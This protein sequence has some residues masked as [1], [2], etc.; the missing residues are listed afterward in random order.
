MKQKFFAKIAIALIIFS[1][2]IS[3]SLSFISSTFSTPH[4]YAGTTTVAPNTD[5]IN[6]QNQQTENTISAQSAECGSLDLFCALGKFFSYILLFVP[7]I[8]TTITGMLFDMSIWHSLQSSTYTKYDG[9]VGNEGV[10]VTGWKLVRDF[11][12][13]L[14]IFALFA[15]AFSLILNVNF[16]LEPKKTIA[17]VVVMAL[18]VNFSFFF[19]RAL[20]DVSNTLALSFYNNMTSAPEMSAA[21]SD[22]DTATKNA[23]GNPAGFY[24]NAGGIRSISAALIS[25]INPHNLVLLSTQSNSTKSWSLSTLVINIVTSFMVAVFNIFLIYIFLSVAILFVARTIGI[26]IAVILSPIAFVSRTIPKLENK[27]YIGF[28]DWLKQLVG[29]AFMGP[30]YL[31]FLYITIQFLNIGGTSAGDGQIFALSAQIFFKLL[32]VGF[33]MY[34]SKKI[35]KDMSGRIGEM[36]VNAVSSVATTGAMF[37]GAAAT[38]G[39][40]GMLQMG[41]RMATDSIK[42]GAINVGTRILGEE[43]VEEIRKRQGVLMNFANNPRAAINASRKIMATGSTG[44]PTTLGKI[45]DAF[46]YGGVSNRKF[47]LEQ[48]AKAADTAKKQKAAADAFKTRNIDKKI[49][50][51]KKDFDDGVKTKKEYEEKLKELVLEKRAVLDPTLSEKN[52]NVSANATLAAVTKERKD[53]SLDTKL[54]TTQSKI[55][56]LDTK[57]ATNTTALANAATKL[58]NAV[59]DRQLANKEVADKKSALASRTN[60]DQQLQAELVSVEK[61]LEGLPKTGF[62]VDR[63]KISALEQKRSDISTKRSLIAADIAKMSVELNNL[64]QQEKIALSVEDAAI[65][66]KDSLEAADIEFKRKKSEAENEKNV[67]EQEKIRLDN[68]VSDAEKNLQTSEINLINKKES[69]SLQNELAARTRVEKTDTDNKKRNDERVSEIQKRLQMISTGGSASPTGT[70]FGGPSSSNGTGTG[71]SVQP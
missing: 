8:I 3:P 12:N 15:I 33:F 37:A 52:A 29:I 63:N 42:S 49:A 57:I 41:R 35:A 18:L 58:A 1:G 11:T 21:L 70:P 20:V 59:K 48:A 44:E 71:G 51:N 28:D 68:A 60:D 25:K 14:F 53:A 16:G 69:I 46:R 36:T 10:V 38:G 26:Y 47:D 19:T 30:I 7:T 65:N 24:K 66:Q 17:R 50:E 4:A 2:V 67:L 55:V 45:G 54:A 22:Y 40:A 9:Q 32:L 27:N 23:L 5:A 43:K 34:Y 62:G 64:E 61:E 13:L 31:F 39:A 6:T 56:D